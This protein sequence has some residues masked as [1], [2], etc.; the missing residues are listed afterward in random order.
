ME[1]T[2]GN[3]AGPAIESRLADPAE[4]VRVVALAELMK[5]EADPARVVSGVAA[6]LDHSSEKV[7]KLAVVVLGKV[8]AK[9]VGSEPAVSALIR[10]LDASQPM[11]VRMF[12]ALGLVQARAAAEPAIEVLCR[13]VIAPA[14][15]YNP[16][17]SSE[18]AAAPG[19]TSA[20]ASPA[21]AKAE[22]GAK[23][24]SAE[25]AK[26]AKPAP[27][28]GAPTPEDVLR[29]NAS[30][31]LSGIGAPAVPWLRRLLRAP[32]P[33]VVTVAI[34]ALGLIG[35]A[36]RDALPDL[37]AMAA[38][39]DPKIR[40]AAAGA[41]V[42]VSGNPAAG[43]PVLAQDLASPDPAVRTATLERIGE[44]QEKGQS[45]GPQVAACLADPAPEV[46]AAAALTLVKVKADPAETVRRL[47]PLLDDP[48]ADVKLGAAQALGTLGP[49]ASPARQRLESI[50]QEKEKDKPL[51]AVA[52]AALKNMGG[53]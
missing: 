5:P 9:G 46:R 25:S 8:A 23:A 50:E 36:A 13:A 38:S 35:P 16:P 37:Q 19:A 32:D 10:G 40:Q 12:A 24:G 51:A 52:K 15:K 3:P 48:S 29:L 22:S 7:R 20:P 33:A 42:K 21:D 47:I 39:T 1:E 4:S 44:L 18:S 49:Q 6:C 31:A 26:P 30:L 14:S 53:P 27:P 41:L 11:P 17:G 45:A 43:L 34:G 28:P 2:T